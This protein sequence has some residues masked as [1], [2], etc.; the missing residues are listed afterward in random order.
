MAIDFVCC[1][2]S[3]C[4]LAHVLHLCNVQTPRG[5]FCPDLRT[6]ERPLQLFLTLVAFH[7]VERL[8]PFALVCTCILHF[9]LSY[10]LEH[11]GASTF[12]EEMTQCIA[13]IL[14]HCC[15]VKCST[16]CF[17]IFQSF[18]SSISSGA[19]LEEFPLVGHRI[20]FFLR[21]WGFGWLNLNFSE[22]SMRMHEVLKPAG[23]R[24]RRNVWNRP[25]RSQLPFVFVQISI[26][27]TARH[28]T[29]AK[30]W[31]HCL[32]AAQNTQLVKCI[33]ERFSSLTVCLNNFA[34]SLSTITSWSNLTLN[35]KLC[36]M[37]HCTYLLITVL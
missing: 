11:F 7:T 3:V 36:L 22:I 31:E 35:V 19:L 28:P 37:S 1:T 20:Q 2:F 29:S 26:K 6:W 21:S 33:R 18:K 25:W 5:P 24:R 13:K 14:N 9:A 32:L 10:G 15:D 27:P 8:V 34:S 23:R 4:E 30:L 17:T 16:L 12:G